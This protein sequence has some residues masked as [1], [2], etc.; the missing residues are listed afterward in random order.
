[1][2]YRTL[3]F[4][5]R[6]CCFKKCLRFSVAYNNKLLWITSFKVA[7]G[8][9]KIFIRKY[10]V[11][12]FFNSFLFLQEDLLVFRIICHSLLGIETKEQRLSCLSKYLEADTISFELLSLLLLYCF[13]TNYHKI[14]ILKH[15]SIHSQFCGAEVQTD[16]SRFPTRVLQS[17]PEV[18][19][20]G[21]FSEGPGEE[22]APSLIQ[23]VG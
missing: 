16:L 13:V 18:W 2:N 3:K 19:V 4:L 7:S 10:V 15:S 12:V 20:T 22:F 6:K 8:R 21:L 17:P 14:S 9:L 23:V 11:G 5:H 1:M